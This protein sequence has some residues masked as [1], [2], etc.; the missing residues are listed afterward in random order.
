VEIAGVIT[1]ILVVSFF[2]GWLWDQT[3]IAARI[4]EYVDA[5]DS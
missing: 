2:L 1:T 5:H 3:P 4:A